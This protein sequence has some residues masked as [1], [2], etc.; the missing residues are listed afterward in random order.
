M[1]GRIKGFKNFIKL[2][3]K[4]EIEKII[5][6]NPQYAYDILLYAYCK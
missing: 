1:L 4:E 5:E 6:E 2:A 3:K